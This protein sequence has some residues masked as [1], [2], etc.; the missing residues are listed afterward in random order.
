MIQCVD[1]GGLKGNDPHR[2][3]ESSAIK[4][5]V[6]LGVVMALLEEVCH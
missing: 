6:L 2:L 3:I 5:C 1:C 4:S